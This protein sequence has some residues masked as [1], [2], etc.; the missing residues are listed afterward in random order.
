MFL[1]CPMLSCVFSKLFTVHHLLKHQLLQ[2]LP[3]WIQL[4]WVKVC[5]PSKMGLG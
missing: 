2:L 3:L 1:S 5:E 4:C